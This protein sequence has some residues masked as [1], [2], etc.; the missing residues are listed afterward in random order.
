VKLAA[1]DIQVEDRSKKIADMLDAFFD[2]KHKDHARCTPSRSATSRSPATARHRPLENCDRTRLAESLGAAFRESLDT[3]GFSNVLG[4]SLTTGAWSPSTATPASSTA[5][6]RS[7]APVPLAD[8]RTQ[9]RVRFGG[10]GDLPIVAEGAP[11]SA[12]GPRRPTRRRPTPAKR[13]GTEDVTLEMI[14]NDDVGMIRRI[15]VRMSAR[16]EAHAR[17][18]RVRLLPH[19][20]D[21]VRRRR[22]LPR[23][24]TATSARGRSTRPRLAA[25][26]WR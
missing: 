9:E 2:P 24:R 8:F 26:A 6:A 10:Y 23:E 13:G 1:G 16:G 21:H 22:V 25:C 3:T 14:K 17:Q 11:T 7:R 19:Q 20:P 4:S 15:P 5:G 18:V 12:L